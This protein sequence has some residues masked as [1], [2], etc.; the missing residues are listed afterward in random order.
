LASRAWALGTHAAAF[1]SAASIRVAT[2]S[3]LAHR[4]ACVCV[5][6]AGADV[7]VDVDGVVVAGADAPATPAT[8]KANEP[9]TVAT[10]ISLRIMMISSTPVTCVTSVSPGSGVE[11]A[12]E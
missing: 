10:A 12:H 5:V 11:P 8:P 6:D 4:V 9:E 2:F 7:D 3:A 1:V